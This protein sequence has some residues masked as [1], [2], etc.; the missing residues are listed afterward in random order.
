MKASFKHSDPGLNRFFEHASGYAI[1][2]GVGKAG[3]GIG[4]ALAL[5]RVPALRV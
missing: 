1:F 4:I 5:K 3:L 2:P